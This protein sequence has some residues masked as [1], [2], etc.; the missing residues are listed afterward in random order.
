MDK[1]QK[2]AD[3]V[4]VL[5]NKRFELRLTDIQ[6]EKLEFKAEQASLKK[7]EFIIRLIEN[8]EINQPLSKQ[9]LIVLTGVANNLNQLTRFA[10]LGNLNIDAILEIVQKLKLVLC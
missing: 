10:H 5:A 4:R 1:K 3:N 9:E 2:K 7:S 8:R 6:L